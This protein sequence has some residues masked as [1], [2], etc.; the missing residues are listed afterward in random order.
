MEERKIRV[1]ITHGD[2]NS[3]GYELIFKALSE[4][5]MLE[6][7]I[8]IIY[9]SPK[10]AAYHR[11]VLGTQA[12]FSIIHQAEEAVEGRLNL[13]AAIEDD[14]KVDMG[15]ATPESGTAAMKALDRAMT[16]FRRGLFDVLVTAPV[17]KTNAQMDGYPFPGHTKFLETCIGEGN[18]ALNVFVNDKMRVAS[19][20]GVE[21]LS[22]VPAA[23]TVE[24]I[25]AKATM[26]HQTLRSDFRI[27][28]PRLA[29]LSM[30]PMVCE[31]MGKEEKEIILPAI[32]QLAEKDIQAFGPYAA[33]D[34]F[35][36]G[37]FADFDATLTMYYDQARIP[38]RMMSE[39]EGVVYTSGLP[40]IRTTVDMETRYDIAGKGK[41]DETG[42]RRALFV[43]MD[44]FRN[45]TMY[46]EPLAN[47]LPK[48]YHEKKED[49]ERVR[50]AIPK[51]H[52][53]EP[54]PSQKGNK[55]APEA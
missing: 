43:A 52:S 37:Y 33:D 50:F 8:P 28:N 22:T 9:G 45:K 54:F 18:N 12:Q 7:C 11:K 49:G 21:P 55:P 47:P 17:N 36:K 41:I 20:T 24:N 6:M 48:L 4:P 38:F 16:D 27:S 15:T 40:L 30:N 19:V 23:I 51:K 39:E 44:V 1:A 3:V 35:G 32:E 26:L 13:L 10:V 53:G 31:E 5:E 14:V 25:V 46:E 2:T 29:I 34:F 42:F